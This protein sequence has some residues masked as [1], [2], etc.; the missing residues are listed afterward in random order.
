M[1]SAF[2]FPG[3][4]AQTVGMGKA[5]FDSSAAAREIY[6][7]ADKL[8]AEHNPSISTKL[9]EIVFNGP[10]DELK[11]TIITQPA[12]ITLSLAIASE[13]K[14]KI[15]SGQ[16]KAPAY[17]AG[18]SLGE[19]AALYMADVLSLEDALKLVI[20]RGALM[21]RAAAGAMSAIVGLDETKLISI[22]AN[23]QGV[24]VANYNAPDQIVIT[25]TAEGVKAAEEAINNVAAAETL[26]VRV[27]SLAVGGAFHS[28]LMQEASN[29]FSKLIDAAN[30]NSAT[31]PVIQNIDA[32]SS[33]DAASIK[34]K[35]KQ[36]MT[37]AVKWTQTVQLLLG[38][39]ITDVWELGPGKVLAGLVKKQDRRF[40]VVNIESQADLDA[41]LTVIV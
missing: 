5:L 7:L 17:T 12:I 9:S 13:L 38:S 41:A 11:R 10:E 34:S 8:F 6:A 27:I 28:P 15:K 21:E 36:Q 23:I 19:F 18:H 39:G 22:I 40:P 24:S 32:T 1:T 4:G 35:L 3:Q 31:I 16:V 2:V 30:F 33:Q 14:S 20:A 37:G 26:K 25:G 29:E